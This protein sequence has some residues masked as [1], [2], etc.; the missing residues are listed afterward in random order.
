M[1]KGKKKK[2][3]RAPVPQKTQGRKYK[4]IKNTKVKKRIKEKTPVFS[5]E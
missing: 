5:N 3:E 4:N 2:K 1:R